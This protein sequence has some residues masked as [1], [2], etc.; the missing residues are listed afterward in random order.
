MKVLN[1]RKILNPAIACLHNS[2][3][4]KS[5]GLENNKQILNKI[6][7]NFN[8]IDTDATAVGAASSAASGFTSILMVV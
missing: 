6:E 4:K 8:K 2:L 7:S 3:S 5:A 1:A